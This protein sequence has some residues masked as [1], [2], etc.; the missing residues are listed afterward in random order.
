MTIGIDT[1]VLDGSAHTSL[2][3]SSR[4]GN[5]ALK[6]AADRTKEV[7]ALAAEWITDEDL[8]LAPPSG[9]E[10][11][12]D[13][14]KRATSAVVLN[15]IV[16][17]SFQSSYLL[18]PSVHTKTYMEAHVL[19]KLKAAG[20]VALCPGTKTCEVNVTIRDR[21]GY[22][23]RQL[24]QSFSDASNS[25]LVNASTQYFPPTLPLP[26]MPPTRPS[27]SPPPSPPEPPQP[28]AHPAPPPS[29]PPPSQPPPSQPIALQLPITLIAE[30]T[31]VATTSTFPLPSSPGDDMTSTQWDSPLHIP[32]LRSVTN[33]SVARASLS[34]VTA[35][36]RVST[37]VPNASSAY[38]AAGSM[39]SVLSNISLLAPLLQEQELNL[40][41]AQIDMLYAEFVHPVDGLVRIVGSLPPP[42]PSQP[43]LEL[44]PLGMALTAAE[45]K[46]VIDVVTVGI[47]L[48][49]GLS[50]AASVATTVVA[51]VSTSMAS[52][53][54]A[55]TAGSASAGAAGGAGGGAGGGSSASSN[56]G[57]A[58][59]PLIFGAQRFG[60]SAGLPVEKSELQQGVA[61]NM[62]WTS[63]DLSGVFGSEGS[64]GPGDAADTGSSTPSSAAAQQTSGTTDSVGRRR[65]KL[66]KK[67]RGGGGDDGAQ[68]KLLAQLVSK[69][70]SYSVV[71]GTLLGVFA[72]GNL[73]FQFRANRKYYAQM[74]V[75][76]KRLGANM[77]EKAVQKLL[78]R[79][80][81][82]I[83]FRPMP[84]LLVFPNLPM[85]A[86]NFFL[87]GL[88]E[89]A[90]AV[91]RNSL[92]SKT[93]TPR[94]ADAAFLFPPNLLCLLHL[95]SSCL[96]PRR[97]MNVVRSATLPLGTCSFSLWLTSLW[98]SCFCCT[99]RGST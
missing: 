82:P 95:P 83:N 92:P 43:E 63:G 27:P 80:K 69:L 88:A 30:R 18:H 29:M 81:K 28:P 45:K 79:Q 85:L 70:I 89:T 46:T 74:E 7:A 14:K 17:V 40:A 60:S 58:I 53:V 87:P 42:P 50:I 77:S 12:G 66:Q 67:G 22:P 98:H 26:S 20:T 47:A 34:L 48:G 35:E 8:L 32:S 2:A 84:G 71:F 6:W 38:D 52:S 39:F 33:V 24:Q 62:G 72:L 90:I 9:I 75:W 5:A 78:A 31:Q 61:G 25:T 10:G 86:T 1:S 51:S 49:V 93:E 76:R 73:Y 16:A 59:A 55:S 57:G 41:G 99:L 65:R 94:H 96:F 97:S 3:A 56:A 64:E 37:L 44:S 21:E 54:A 36:L 23:G 4:F 15:D 11:G 68:R 13:G 91:S 19:P